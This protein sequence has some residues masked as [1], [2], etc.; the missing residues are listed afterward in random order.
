MVW[1]NK[2]KNAAQWTALYLWLI[3]GT[4][5]VTINAS[6]LYW[7]NAIGQR[8]AATVNLSLGQLMTNYYQLLAYLNFP[9]VPRLV[10]NDFTDSAGALR[11]FADV[12]SLFMLTDVVF[13]VTSVIVYFFYRQL[14]RRQQ[15]WRFVLPMQTALWVPPLVTVIM[16]INFDQF[17]VWFHELLFSNSDWLFDPLLD[18][19]IIVLPESF[20]AQC[21]GLA[22]IL[23]EGA[24]WVHLML[25]KQALEQLKS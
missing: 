14:K 20:F 23:I 4:V 10:M 7:L 19:I 15:L 9:W 1:L 2:L 21:F 11:H 6:W 3:S 16:A 24:F 22:F 5:I 12:K 17:F 18:R 8:L 25:G 13:I